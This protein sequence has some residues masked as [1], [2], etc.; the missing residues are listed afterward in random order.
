[1]S[2]AEIARELK[3]TRSTAGNAI[4]ALLDSGLVVELDDIDAPNKIGRPSVGVSVNPAGA[5]AIGIDIGTRVVSGILVNLTMQVIHK[6]TVPNGTTFRD[7]KATTA[8]VMTVIKR[9]QAEAGLPASAIAGAAVS[10]PGLVA[11]GG[12][13]VNAPFLEWRDFP[14]Q[15]LLT[16]QL[17]ED[18]QVL[19]RND[20]VAL[21]TAEGTTSKGDQSGSLLVVLLAEGIG[22]ALVQDGNVLEGAHGQAG[23]IGHT[24]LPSETGP[25]SFE[26]LAGAPA[27]VDFFGPDIP[28]DIAV[29][30]FL[31]RLPDRRAELQLDTWCRHMAVGLANAIHT[32]DPQRVVLG[33][34]LA[35]L[36]AIREQQT[37]EALK[38]LL[39]PGFLLPDIAV[40]GYAAD[41][42]AVG[43]AATVLNSLFALPD[44][45]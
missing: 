27:F 5:Y 33:G 26:M 37:L 11:T 20:A 19:V 45:S 32:L 28:V 9:L 44:F 2:R 36:Y 18:W 22:S 38:G 21:A 34:P 4:K 12:I 31:T 6:V 10:V 7:P 43:A 17:P 24:I 41:G 8:K 29:S 39:M 13:V 15:S 30:D 3:L 16:E 14:L 42:A 35:L 23:E 25:A 1:M 40:T